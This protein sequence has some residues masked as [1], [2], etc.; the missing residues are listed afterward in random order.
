MKTIKHKAI[1]TIYNLPTLNK[2]ELNRL[3]EWLAQTHDELANTDIKKYS[4]R[5]TLRLM[6]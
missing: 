1:L 2:K 6:K 3:L 4:K 5:Y